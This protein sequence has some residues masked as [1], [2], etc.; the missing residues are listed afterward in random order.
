MPDK[1]IIR[2][3]SDL[4]IESTLATWRKAVT[5]HQNIYVDDDNFQLLL[6]KARFLDTLEIESKELQAKL[7]F[8]VYPD[9]K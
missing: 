5:N 8:I 1:N 4:N 7:L 3:V 2:S 6:D 9:D